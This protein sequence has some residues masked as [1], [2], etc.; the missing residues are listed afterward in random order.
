V[1][2]FSVVTIN[3]KLLASRCQEETGNFVER[4]KPPRQVGRSLDES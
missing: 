4:N 2:H 3:D 1:S